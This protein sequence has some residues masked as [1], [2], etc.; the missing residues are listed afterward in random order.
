M[1]LKNVMLMGTHRNAKPCNMDGYP[2]EGGPP[3][4]FTNGNG[5]RVQYCMLPPLSI[6]P[7]L[8]KFSYVQVPQLSELFY[9]LKTNH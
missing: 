2:A 7:V 9:F 3:L 8:Y 4:D 5:Q 6:E 1:I